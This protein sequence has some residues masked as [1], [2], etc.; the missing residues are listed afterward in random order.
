MDTLKHKLAQACDG[1]AIPGT[2]GKG[3]KRTRYSTNQCK[4]CVV[5]VEMPATAPEKDPACTEKR[6]VSIYCEDRRQLWLDTKDAEW[7]MT[8]V[9]H[10]LEC[11]L[12]L[13]VPP[14]EGSG[15]EG[16]DSSDAEIG[17]DSS[18]E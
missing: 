9:Q 14:P 6:M 13:V 3:G 10:Q 15:P 17:E 1:C 8:Y 12:V 11:D 2:R 7:A 16:S 5:Q 18:V 4:G